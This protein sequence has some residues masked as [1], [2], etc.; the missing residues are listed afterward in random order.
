MSLQVWDAVDWDKSGCAQI[1]IPSCWKA[2]T[3]PSGFSSPIRLKHHFAGLTASGP[4]GDTY[5]CEGLRKVVSKYSVAASDPQFWFSAH[6]LFQDTFFLAMA[7][8]TVSVLYTGT[9]HAGKSHCSLPQTSEPKTARAS[10]VELFLPESCGDLLD[11][12]S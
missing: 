6:F 4:E 10:M 5:A 9:F 7:N 12:S 8:F 3:Y 2:W 11:S 1:L